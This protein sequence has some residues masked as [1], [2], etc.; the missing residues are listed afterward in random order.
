[1]SAFCSPVALRHWIGRPVQVHLG[2]TYYCQHLRRRPVRGN[3]DYRKI[4]TAIYS[5]SMGTMLSDEQPHIYRCR[6]CCT[7]LYTTVHY[8]T[9][10]FTTGHYWALLHTTVNTAVG[11]ALSR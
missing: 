6:H 5:D 9:L 3:T 10:L 8:C 1:M 11:L 2:T 7:L 4:V